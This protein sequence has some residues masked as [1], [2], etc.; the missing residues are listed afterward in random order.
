M[1]ENSWNK[2]ILS[3]ELFGKTISIFIIF[4]LLLLCC[5]CSA[6]S[7]KKVDEEIM[8]VLSKCSSMTKI[9][10]PNHKK[11]LYTYY[12]PPDMG[13]FKSNESGNVFLKNGYHIVMNLNV[14]RFIVDKYYQ[15]EENKLEDQEVQ[16]Y[17]EEEL[18]KNSLE[19]SLAILQKN[20]VN[21]KPKEIKK[22]FKITKKKKGDIFS[23]H[24]YYLNYDLE[25]IP[26][27]LSLKKDENDYF[28]Y[29]DGTNASVVTIV[30]AEEVEDVLY[31]SMMI[32]KSM[33]CDKEAIYQS[34]SLQYDITKMK[35]IE[36]EEME[37]IPLP[38]EGYLEDL[39]I[40]Q[41]RNSTD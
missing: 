15:I 33:A 2:E 38:S 11:T 9:A 1:K 12:L 14:E 17:T 30:P 31:S 21:N 40:Q 23:Y 4:S 5:G 39:I 8:Q 28:I 41:M 34:Y 22:N 25:M 32:L 36:L 10:D 35:D 29:L 16:T 7:S 26:Y 13:V 19:Q 20:K 27:V 18:L 6:I 37:S 24:G 3:I